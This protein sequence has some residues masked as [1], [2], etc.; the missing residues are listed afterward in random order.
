[1]S[2]ISIKE[3][4]RKSRPCV[5]IV[6]IR[7]NGYDLS[8]GKRPGTPIMCCVCDSF[9]CLT[10]CKVTKKSENEEAFEKNIVRILRILLLKGRIGC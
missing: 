8:E 3:V 4:K 5:G 7:F 10:R 1:M 9:D 2:T 6:R